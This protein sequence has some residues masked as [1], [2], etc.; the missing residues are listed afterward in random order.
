ME[1][2]AQLG[3]IGTGVDQT[4]REVARMA[5]GK[6]DPFHPI[7]VVHEMQQIGQGVLAASLGGDARQ[8]TAVGVDV[9][10]QE[11]DLL[12]ALSSEALHLQLDRFRHP[13]LLLAPH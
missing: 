2:L 8:I 5:G 1:V 9:L 7:H 10:P 3:Q 12:E 6:A 13:R 11:S 4:L